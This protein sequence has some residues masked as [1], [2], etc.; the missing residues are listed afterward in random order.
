MKKI[1]IAISAILLSNTAFAA[2]DTYVRNGN[3]YSHQ[4]QFSVGAGVMTG[5][6]FYKE[7]DDKTAAYLNA[8]YHGE[9]FNA[10]LTGVN[11]RFFGTN[12]STINF[13]IFAVANPGFDADDAKILTGMKDRKISGDLGL[14]ADIHLGQ[15]TL[16]IKFQHDV[17]GVYDGYQADVAYY[18]PMNIG[19]AD[20]VPYVGVHYFSDDYVNYYTGVSKEDATIKRTVYKGEGS[21]AYKAGYAM[22]IPVT[23]NLDITQAT[24]YVRLGS[25]MADSPLVDSQNQWITT[26]GVNYSF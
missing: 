16:S 8:G 4:G 13:S 10:D 24:A 26:L 3:V 20:L 25:S 7:Q 2:G 23:D 9:D 14:N 12:D 22:V 21:F 11:Y 6:E 18:H 5:S 19:F 17:T 15:D 1:S